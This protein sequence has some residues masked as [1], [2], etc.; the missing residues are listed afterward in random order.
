MVP[1]D[2]SSW[3]GKYW[4]VWLS[5]VTVALFIFGVQLSHGVLFAARLQSNLSLRPPDKS[6]HLKIADTQ[7]Q[8][9]QFAD[10]NVRS[11]FLKMRPPEKCELRT[12]EVG[13]KLQFNL[14]KATTY[15][16]LSEK[17]FFNRPASP[18]QA[19]RTSDHRVCKLGLHMVVANYAPA[20]MWELPISIVDDDGSCRGMCTS[21][22]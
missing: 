21:P 3:L 5:V 4:W 16:K 20:C 18:S 22:Y 17:H 10:S 6:D 11:A 12:P 1:L 7:I 15:V 8:S 2:L 9:L 13:P 19:L 14:E